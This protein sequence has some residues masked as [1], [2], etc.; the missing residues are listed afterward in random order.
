MA[1][2]EA[3]A[4][5]KPVVSTELG[6]G[7]SWVNQNEHTGLVVRP[8]DSMDLHQALARLVADPDLRVRFGS[9]ARDRALEHFTSEI[10]CDTTRSLYQDLTHDGAPLA[11]DHAASIA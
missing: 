8:G 5:G 4:C 6:T 11:Q 9:C 10:A 2:L 7:T 1:L 3:M